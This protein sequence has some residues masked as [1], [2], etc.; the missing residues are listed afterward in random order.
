MY[1]FPPLLP[2]GAQASFCQ[3]LCL[4]SFVSPE[5]NPYLVLINHLVNICWINV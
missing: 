5:L 2:V 3:G 1:L 4:F